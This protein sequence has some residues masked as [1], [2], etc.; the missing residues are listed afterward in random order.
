MAKSGSAG[1]HWVMGSW[2][3]ANPRKWAAKP[4]P[5][6]RS[7]SSS[8][9]AFTPLR[10]GKKL[11]TQASQW[12]GLCHLTCLGSMTYFWRE[13]AL[14]LSHICVRYKISFDWLI[15]TELFDD[16][17]QLSVYFRQKLFKRT[18]VNLCVPSLGVLHI[19]DLP[20]EMSK[21]LS[22]QAVHHCVQNCRK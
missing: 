6:Q 7:R 22:H 14:L 13:T 1:A 18:L 2:R 11:A 12:Y 5:I 8:P 9:L 17:S 21:P 3:E 10:A 19:V 20:W 15:Y 16:N 4:L